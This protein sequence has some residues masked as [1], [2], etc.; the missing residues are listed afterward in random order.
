MSVLKRFFCHLIFVLPL[1]DF[2]GKIP[3]SI[4]RTAGKSWSGAERR[5]ATE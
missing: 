4:S 1:P 2:R 5:M 3:F